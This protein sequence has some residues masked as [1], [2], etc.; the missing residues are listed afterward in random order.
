MSKV[1]CKLKCIE[2]PSDIHP[3]EI[4]LKY[5]QI[6]FKRKTI[7]YPSLKQRAGKPYIVLA[8]WDKNLYGN[9]PTAI[10]DPDHPDSKIRPVKIEFFTKVPFT[11][12]GCI[13]HLFIAVVSWYSPHSNH[14]IFGKPVKVWH[15][16]QFE[17]QGVHTYLP[18]TK[19]VSHCAYCMRIIEDEILLLTIPLIE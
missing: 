19:I 18:I 7:G 14:N 10:P 6:H 13:D 5:S 11:I 3:N 15:S 17:E 1:Y 8:E 16:D 4:Y 12:K 2:N 9:P